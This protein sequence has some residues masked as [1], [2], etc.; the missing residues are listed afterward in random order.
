MKAVILEIAHRRGIYR[1]TCDGEFQGDYT[2]TH[3]ATESADEMARNLRH[4]GRW[5]EIVVSPNEARR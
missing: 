2:K 5:V 3:W 4:Q 1:V